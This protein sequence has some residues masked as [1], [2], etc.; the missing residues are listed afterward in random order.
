MG[1]ILLSVSGEGP[2]SSSHLEGRGHPGE[3]CPCSEAPGRARGSAR[4]SAPRV[5]GSYFSSAAP[6]NQGDTCGDTC[7]DTALAPAPADRIPGQL[8]GASKFEEDGGSSLRPR[9]VVPARERKVNVHA[10]SYF[11]IVRG[12]RNGKNEVFAL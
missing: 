10:V 6:G 4:R 7:W 9:R 2:L 3:A 12:G 1:K 11:Q 5:K 8:A